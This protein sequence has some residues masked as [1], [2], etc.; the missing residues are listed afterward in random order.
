MSKKLTPKDWQ[1][2]S[3]YLDDQLKAGQKAQVEDR[4]RIDE[5]FKSAY[6]SLRHTQLLLHSLPTRRVTRNF[7]LTAAMIKQSK[8]LLPSFAGVLRFS[9][10]AAG[11]MLIL[12]LAFDF[13]PGLAPEIITARS[14]ETAVLTVEEEIGD[15]K[16]M[17]FIFQEEQLTPDQ[18]DDRDTTEPAYGLGGGGADEVDLEGAPDLTIQAE[19]VPLV[20][21]V[22]A[23]EEELMQE[24]GL[25]SAEKSLWEPQRALEISQINLRLLEVV[26]G[27]IA[28][29]TGG[30]AYWLNK[31]K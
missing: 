26:V 30:L 27:A 21:G 9:S 11:L 17:P 15:T 29:I 12:L 16:E 10:V 8:P 28:A 1:L 6:Q 5:E 23:P 2:L 14:Q 31:K 25:S 19:E 4:L 22:P 3:A 13:F 18:L 24:P 7:T 20:E